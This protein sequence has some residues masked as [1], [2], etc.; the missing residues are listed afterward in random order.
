MGLLN[1]I[2]ME[3]ERRKKAQKSYFKFNARPYQRRLIQTFDEGARFFLVCWARRLGKDLFALSVTCRECIKNPNT[4]AYYIFPTMKQGRMMILDGYTERKTLILEE[5][6]ERSCLKLPLKSDKLYHSDNSVR[7]KNGS[8]IYFVGAQD[9]NTKVGGH[10]D[11]L[12]ISEM[13]TIQSKDILTYL[14]PSTIKVGGKIILV[15]TPRFGSV[16]NEMLEKAGEEW[17]RSILKADDSEVVDRDGIPIYTNEQLDTAKKLM[18]DSK[19]RQEYYCDVEIANEEAIYA[20]SLSKAKWVEEISIDKKRLYVSEDLGINDST[21]LTFLVD[22]TVIHH[23]ANVDKPTMHYITYIKQ[24]MNRHRVKEVSIIL[25]HDAKNRH[26]AIDY[27]TSRRE[28]YSKHF[29][30]VKVLRAYDV[31]KTIEI[32]KHS[33]ESGKVKFLKCSN[34]LNMVKLMKKYEWRVDNSTGENLRTP[35]HGRGISASNTCDSFEYYCMYMFSEQYEL[36][37]KEF[38]KLNYLEYEDDEEAWSYL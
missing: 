34:V 24:F 26:D 1:V 6:I 7:F 14:I 15:S 20:F 8:I 19:F 11:L 25:P 27:L 3:R 4:V 37:L 10:L 22:H 17:H 33:I 13:A 35:I 28:A 9:A 18:S 2:Q 32:A 29:D 23:Y 12:V 36:N 30:S 5:V 31:H 16:F 38:D 21:A